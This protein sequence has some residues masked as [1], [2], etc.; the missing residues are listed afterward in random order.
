[1]CKSIHLFNFKKK[2]IHIIPVIWQSS[3]VPETVSQLDFSFYSIIT[4]K[5]TEM[6][7]HKHTLAITEFCFMFLLKQLQHRVCM[8]NRNWLS[9]IAHTEVNLFWYFDFVLIKQSI[10]SK[11]NSTG[12]SG[13]KHLPHHFSTSLE[14]TK[15]WLITRK[16]PFT[17]IKVRQMEKS[18]HT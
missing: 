18:R 8:K 7:C 9:V 12:L 10:I 17:E 16:S 6:A 14:L 2:K 11:Q 3:S 4:V 5:W 1:M 13:P 15:Y